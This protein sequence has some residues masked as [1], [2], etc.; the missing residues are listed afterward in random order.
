ML[1]IPM[2]AQPDL[3]NPNRFGRWLALLCREFV[4]LFLLVGT[5][6]LLAWQRWGME[7]TFIIDSKSGLVRATS[8]DDKSEGGSSTC[9]IKTDSNGWWLS[10]DVRKGPNWSFCGL[11][12]AFVDGDSAVGRDLS[13]F[14][15]LVVNMLGMQGPNERLQIQIKASDARL[16]E[17]AGFETLKYHDMVLIPGKNGP[18]RTSMPLDNFVIP[19]WWAGRYNIPA[20]NLNPTREDVREI[21]FAT[22][23]DKIVLGTG[24]FGVRNLEFHGKWVRQDAL[25]K[26]LLGIWLAYIAGGLVRRLYLSFQEIRDLQGQTSHLRDLSERDPLTLL[27]NRRGL[28]NRLA[29]LAE[30]CVGPDNQALGVLMV[31]LDHFKSVNDT[32][33]H[34]AGDQVLRILSGILLEEMRPNN[35]AARW[36]GEEFILLLPGIPPERL[37]PAAERLRTRVET[38]LRYNGMSFTASIGGALGVVGDFDALVK[39]ADD[40]LYRAKANGR[41]RVELA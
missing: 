32:L 31:D 22:S 40:A 14:D 25:L 35:I 36:G 17:E 20:R 8:F 16:L 3:D 39:R 4:V 28:E 30:R 41:N 27:H 19:P 37:A 7:R 9:T 26:I 10:Y 5:M 1:L 15:T 33:G 34:D 13:S 6:G 29:G 21:E 11:N 24:M 38:D 23:A 18:S 12:L 2:P